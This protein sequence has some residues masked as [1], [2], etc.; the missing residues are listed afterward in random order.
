MINL[1]DKHKINPTTDVFP[2]SGTVL[3]PTL[4]GFG[5]VSST[6]P[7]VRNLERFLVNEE[8]RQDQGGGWQ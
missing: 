3:I 8:L 6:G 1:R 2:P 5:T 7:V 4:L